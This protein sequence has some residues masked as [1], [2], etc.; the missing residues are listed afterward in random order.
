[1][2]PSGSL[3]THAIFQVPLAIR[4]LSRVTTPSY[5]IVRP[6]ISAILTVTSNSCS[7]LSGRWYSHEAATR[8]Q[9]IGD[10]GG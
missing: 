5:R 8:G 4:S 2:L 9:P 6:V 3:L 7:N 1:M 10:C